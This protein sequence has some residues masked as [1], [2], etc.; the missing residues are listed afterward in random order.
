MLKPIVSQLPLVPVVLSLFDGIGGAKL[1]LKKVGVMKCVYIAV[2][3]DVQCQ[4]LMRL[5]WNDAQDGVLV[6]LNDVSELASQADVLGALQQVVGMGEINIDLCIGG[7]PCN[8]FAGYNRA[9]GV[10]G[11]RGLAGSK[12]CLLFALSEIVT[13]LCAQPVFGKAVDPTLPLPHFT[14]V[15]VV[16]KRKSYPATVI[17]SI[18]RKVAD[19]MD[20]TQE[21]WYKL[22]FVDVL[23]PDE[24][25]CDQW[26]CSSCVFLP[27]SQTACPEP[28]AGD[29]TDNCC[30]CCGSTVSATQEQVDQ[31][32]GC[33][34]FFHHSCMQAHYRTSIAAFEGQAA[35]SNASAWTSSFCW[36]CC[37][38]TPAARVSTGIDTRRRR[39]S[40]AY[41]DDDGI[42][43]EH[44]TCERCKRY[45]QEDRMIL[46]DGRECNRAFHMDC[47][48][49]PLLMIPEG[50]WICPLCNAAP[51]LQKGTDLHAVP[52]PVGQLQLPDQ[53]PASN[54]SQ[55]QL[56]PEERVAVGL[57]VE[58]LVTAT[59]RAA[60][61]ESR[62]I[63]DTVECLDVNRVW[64]ASRVV[65]LRGHGQKQTCCVGGNGGKYLVPHAVDMHGDSGRQLLIH[66]LGWPSSWDEWISCFSDRIQPR[67]TQD[68]GP[69]KNPRHSAAPTAQ[70]SSVAHRLEKLL[71][72]QRDAVM[73][74]FEMP[75][76]CCEAELLAAQN[77]REMAAHA[78]IESQVR[79]V[80]GI[81]VRRVQ[82]ENHERQQAARADQIALTVPCGD[83]PREIKSRAVT[84][85]VQAAVKRLVTQ[86]ASRCQAEAR[87]LQRQLK[88]RQQQQRQLQRQLQLRQRKAQQEERAATL[89]AKQQQRQVERQRRKAQQAEQAA[90]L[91]CKRVLQ[92]LSRSV[93]AKVNADIKREKRQ[94][95]ELE[96]VVGDLVARVERCARAQPS[97]ALAV[98]SGWVQL[99]CM[100]DVYWDAAIEPQSDAGSC[101][102]FTA[103]VQ[104]LPRTA[105]Q[106]Y[107][108]QQ[109]IT[110]HY[111]ESDTVEYVTLRDAWHVQCCHLREPVSPSP[112]SS[113][114]A[115]RQ[116]HASTILTVNSATGTVLSGH[117]ASPSCVEWPHGQP[118]LSHHPGLQVQQPMYYVGCKRPLLCDGAIA[119]L[120]G[121]STRVRQAQRKKQL[122]GF[123]G[124]QHVANAGSPNNLGT[125]ASRAAVGQPFPRHPHHRMPSGSQGAMAHL[126]FLQRENAALRDTNARLIAELCR[127]SSLT[128]CDVQWPPRGIIAT[129]HDMTKGT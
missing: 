100:L 73:P 65:G 2:E 44:I 29:T 34:D 79:A 50:D 97:L 49:P 115:A 16:Q 46:C 21:L 30:Y 47:L 105:S 114:D 36:K 60:W 56:S 95:F 90:T 71:L 6:Q 128:G 26:F 119:D 84:R 82:Q 112:Q 110:L 74:A 19:G 40:A 101:G 45:D 96:I 3:I 69:S 35:P 66:F 124:S 25:T 75:G 83:A 103:K 24:E 113:I 81:L 31:C 122:V 28:P 43:A 14:K 8:N 13:Q 48:D 92:K 55:R 42:D 38:P 123:G 78:A 64:Y 17:D 33:G 15:L 51:A 59:Q 7:W 37:H 67:G 118:K 39:S 53:Q 107:L 80:L 11:R 27:Q 20:D 5:H 121:R 62:Q 61:R 129:R 111:V 57:V 126:T 93:E 125:L 104:N 89:R 4:R 117:T 52:A 63:G 77:W 108:P 68:L 9:E 102:W 98:V 106:D 32:L 88:L 94:L 86:V 22:R 116:Q 76:L 127:L 70:L 10:H 91:E 85:S 58:Q 99:G 41:R 23:A 12:S 18:R 120:D 54:D 87:T 1:A 109:A 72:R